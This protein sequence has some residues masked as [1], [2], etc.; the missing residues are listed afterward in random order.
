[1]SSADTCDLYK[2][3]IQIRSDSMTGLSES[4]LFETAMVFIKEIEK[5]HILKFEKVNRRL[6]SLIKH[7]N[8]NAKKNNLTALPATKSG[9]YY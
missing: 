2:P 8:K 1:M 3:S 9:W 5:K 4:Q 6:L 7:Y